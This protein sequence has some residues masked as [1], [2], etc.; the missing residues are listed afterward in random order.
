MA[1]KSQQSLRNNSR[2]RNRNPQEWKKNK[3]KRLP[4]R[5]KEQE[6]VSKSGEK[7]KF[8]AKQLGTD[9]RCPLKCFERV[10][11]QQCENVFGGFWEIGLHRMPSYVEV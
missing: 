1:D 5:G 9:C 7:R 3:H 8:A 6:T 11:Q 10:T 2:K 4:N